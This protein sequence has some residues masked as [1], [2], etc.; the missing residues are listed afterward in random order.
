MPRRRI[1]PDAA[2]AR[3]TLAAVL[4]LALTACGR[5]KPKDTLHHTDALIVCP[6]AKSIYWTWFHGED[7]LGYQVDA[8][9]PADGVISC[10]SRQLSANGWQPLSYDIC[11]PNRPSS[12]VTGWTQ[13]MDATVH[14]EATVDQWGAQWQNQTGDIAWYLLQYTYPPGDRLTVSVHA[15]LI[16]ADIAK[17]MP[18]NTQKQK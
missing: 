6:G 5:W 10:I 11:N 14:P 1:A 4:A 2:L 9:Y 16:A 13:F 7:Q 8:E 15:G 12:Q 3:V 17:K 18:Q